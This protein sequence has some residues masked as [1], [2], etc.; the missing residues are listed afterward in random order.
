MRRTKRK[1]KFYYLTVNEDNNVVEVF[2]LVIN[3]I[4]SLFNTEKSMI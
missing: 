2:N 1:I 3:Y 4:N